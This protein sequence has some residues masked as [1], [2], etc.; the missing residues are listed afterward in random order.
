VIRRLAEDLNL[1]VKILV[2]PTVREADGLAKS[3]RNVYLTWVERKA[4]TVLFPCRT[5]CVR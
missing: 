5:P 4:S 2:S 1:G 3:S